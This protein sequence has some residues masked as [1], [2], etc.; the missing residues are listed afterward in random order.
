MTKQMRQV[1]QCIANLAPL[2]M[3]SMRRKAETVEAGLTTQHRSMINCRLALF[4][5]PE[6]GVCTI[7]LE[8]HDPCDRSP[9]P[10]QRRRTLCCSPG[11]VIFHVEDYSV[12]AKGIHPQS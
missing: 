4:N 9:Q 2:L 8:V 5:K 1:C 3:E 12:S 6:F 10:S 11:R 7:V